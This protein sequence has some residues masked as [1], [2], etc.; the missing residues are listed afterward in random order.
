MGKI[1]AHGEET[2]TR[3]VA[4]SK[5]HLHLL[6]A[7]QLLALEVVALAH[8]D[9]V[10]VEVWTLTD[11]YRVPLSCVNHSGLVGALAELKVP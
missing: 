10:G 2:P 7:T 8:I 1:R 4:R 6:L 9:H 5:H 11:L 3:L